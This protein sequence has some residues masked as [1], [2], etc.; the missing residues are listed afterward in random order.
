[1]DLDGMN[2]HKIAQNI[3][4]YSAIK[5]IIQKWKE[6]SMTVTLSRELKGSDWVKK[7]T[8]RSTLHTMKL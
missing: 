2:L 1:M 6:Y 3:E 4:T 7:A 5:S 8:K